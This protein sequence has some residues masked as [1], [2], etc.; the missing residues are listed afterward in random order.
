MSSLESLSAQTGL[1]DG[2]AGVAPH[3]DSRRS[4]YWLANHKNGWQF[5][6]QGVLDAIV[7]AINGDIPDEHRWCVEFGAGDGTALPITC[8]RLMRR[9]GWRS[10]LIDADPDCVTKLNRI[11]PN[12][13]RVIQGMVKPEGTDTIDRYM[14]DTGCPASPA[15]MVVDVD[16]IDF[17]IVRE[18]KARPYVLCME[19]MDMVCPRFNDEVFVPVMDDA[20]QPFQVQGVGGTFRL[21][22]NTKALDVMVPTLGY[23]LVFR[24]RVNSIYVRSDMVDKV[25]RPVDGAIRLNIGAGGHSDPRYTNIDIKDGADGRKLP[26]EDGTVEEV[27]SSHLLEHFKPNEVDAL[28][29]EWVRVLRPFGTLRIAVPDIKKLAAKV[30]NVDEDCGPNGYRDLEMMI[31]GAHSDATDKH[32]SIF[33]EAKLTQTMNRAGIGFVRKFD[34][35]IV[36]D[37]SNYDISLNLEGVKRWS[38]KIEKPSVVL[39]LNQPRFTFSGHEVSLLE[40]ARKVDFNIQTCKGSFWDRDMTAATKCAVASYDPDFLFYSDYDSVFEVEDV[41]KL[42]ETI[43][44]DPTMAAIGAV[45]M[46]RHNDRPLVMEDHLDYSKPTT[47]VN[48]QHF[49]CMIIRREVFDELPQPWFWS[50]PGKDANGQWN[51]DEWT[52]SDADI[53]FWRNLTRMGF[54]VYQHN[55][56][57]IG[58][59]VQ[60]VKYPRD[61]GRGV[62]LIPIENYWQVGKPTDAKFNEACYKPKPVVAPAV[63]SAPKTPTLQDRT[64]A[65]LRTRGILP[66]GFEV[67]PSDSRRRLDEDKP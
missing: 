15:V 31:C 28:L 26:Y 12:T 51:W 32:A 55:E 53:S 29:A 57:C 17:Y 58:H 16:S 6:E 35:F 60:A 39:V 22:A 56:V 50:V 46:S 11:V 62:Q 36:D 64:D 33:T 44:N 59:I 67:P 37:C 3:A 30:A 24:T 54:K 19:H 8:E 4:T 45:Q 63:E 66:S 2:S 25:S 9:A 5:G 21:Q 27:Y 18:M 10:L 42:L 14:A 34:P 13:A 48:F 49:G 38:H 23:T 41:Q 47:R 1:S 7:D 43:N 40:L 20:G 65:E 52:K 61:K